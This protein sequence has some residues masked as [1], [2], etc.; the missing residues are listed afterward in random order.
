MCVHLHSFSS[1]WQRPQW[2]SKCIN[3]VLVCSFILFVSFIQR[4]LI[5][6]RVSPFCSYF[7]VIHMSILSFSTGSLIVMDSYFAW[8]WVS[9]VVIT[10]SSDNSW[11]CLTVNEKAVCL[12]WK[13]ET[14]F[15]HCNYMLN[16]KK[17]KI[18]W[19]FNPKI[20]YIVHKDQVYC[21]PISKQ[22]Q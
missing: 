18:S 22:F 11:Q 10:S 8:Y 21:P 4:H 9:P 16:S 13:E 20:R 3:K 7:S 19:R 14:N 15:T 2:V 17:M 12:L 6:F 1:D 5:F